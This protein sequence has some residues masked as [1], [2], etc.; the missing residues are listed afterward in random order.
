MVSGWRLAAGNREE[1]ASH[2]R[3]KVKMVKQGTTRAKIV[4][5]SV[6]VEIKTYWIQDVLTV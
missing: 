3:R 1:E 5:S 2:V 4:K 6:N